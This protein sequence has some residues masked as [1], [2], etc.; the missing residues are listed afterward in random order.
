VIYLD[1]SVVLARLFAEGPQLPDQSWH[2]A[3]TSSLLLQFEVWNRLHARGMNEQREN[4]ARHLLGR[5]QLVELAPHVLGRALKPF[6]T[7]VRT[8]D[9]LHLATMDYLSREGENIELATFDSRMIVAARA[10]GIA[11]HTR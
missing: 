6:P 9:G 8:L 4:H 10:L 3:L 11:I 1:S 5:I 7:D 2:E